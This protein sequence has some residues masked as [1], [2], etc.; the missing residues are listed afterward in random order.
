MKKENIAIFA[1][2]NGSNAEKF[3]EYFRNHQSIK[4]SCL[5]SNN[6]TAFALTRA[7]NNGIPSMWFGRN[8]FKE[9]IKIQNYLERHN[10]SFIVLAGFMWLVPGYLIESF[11]DRIVNIH[12]ALLPKH[13][14]KGMYGHHVHEAVIENNEDE[15][16]ITIH[17]VNEVY[18]DGKILFQAKCKV[19]PGDDANSLATRIHQLEYQYYPIVVDAILSGKEM[20]VQ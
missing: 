12:P 19:I 11:P 8:E 1:S 18:D 7:E 6:K 2:G 17:Y 16:G 10:I 14:G 5:I 20:P 4:V 15:S 13:G 9:G 3:F